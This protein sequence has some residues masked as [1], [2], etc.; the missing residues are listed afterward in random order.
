MICICMQKPELRPQGLTHQ[1]SSATSGR[2]FSNKLRW[3]VCSIRRLQHWTRTWVSNA[4]IRE[5]YWKKNEG[6]TSGSMYTQRSDEECLETWQLIWI[7]PIITSVC[8]SHSLSLWCWISSNIIH[9]RNSHISEPMSSWHC[10]L[11]NI[12][13]YYISRLIMVPGHAARR[14]VPAPRV[15]LSVCAD[16]L[17]HSIF[18]YPHRWV[19]VLLVTRIILS[20]YLFQLYSLWS[21]SCSLVLYLFSGPLAH[22]PIPSPFHWCSPYYILNPLPLPYLRLVTQSPLCPYLTT[23]LWLISFHLP[24]P[25]LLLTA[26]SVLV[27]PTYIN[28]TYYGCI[29]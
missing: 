26:W 23:G 18:S 28:P 16:S 17:P 20:P 24:F 27:S 7:P 21:L 13:L 15:Q 1:H 4:V 8:S 22:S 12:W 10:S 19:V 2:P 25:V 5:I 11:N 14:N 6:A 29:L 3:L 9:T